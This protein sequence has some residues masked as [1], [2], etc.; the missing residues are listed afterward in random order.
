MY[1]L[2]KKFAKLNPETKIEYANHFLFSGLIFVSN[3]LPVVGFG[4]YIIGSLI[5]IQA[6]EE[7]QDKFSKFRFQYMF[8]QYCVGFMLGLAVIN[9]KI[10]QILTTG[11]VIAYFWNSFFKKYGRR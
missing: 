3:K 9:E 4:L 1:N 11:V 7:K 10:S 8:L 6:Y 2:L 5:L